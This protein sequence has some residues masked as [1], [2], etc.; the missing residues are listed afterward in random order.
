MKQQEARLPTAP[1]ANET[2]KVDSE[3]APDMTA[4]LQTPQS[5]KKKRRSFIP[6]PGG[7]VSSG[8]DDTAGPPGI[9]PK[10]V[11]N[12]PR[13]DTLVTYIITWSP[14]MVSV[15]VSSTHV[16]SYSTHTQE[17]AAHIKIS[18]PILYDMNTL[19]ATKEDGGGDVDTRGTSPMLRDPSLTKRSMQMPPP[20]ARKVLNPRTRP[21]GLQRLRGG[22]PRG[23][24]AVRQPTVGSSRQEG[25]LKA[26]VGI[27]YLE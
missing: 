19:M 9:I 4:R 15:T 12:F 14:H 3:G 26:K 10:G 24:F 2:Y 1:D 17:R 11:Q 18:S 27:V 23:V 6:T 13:G 16:T 25:P 21:S 8:F 5:S 22:R 7:Q 20:K